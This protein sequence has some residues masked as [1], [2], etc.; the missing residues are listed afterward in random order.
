MRGGGGDG[1]QVTVRKS[2]FDL[3]KNVLRRLQRLVFPMHFGRSDG[4]PPWGGGG[5]QGGGVYRAGGWYESQCGVVV[6]GLIV[7]NAKGNPVPF[8]CCFLLLTYFCLYH[9]AVS[10]T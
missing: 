3:K 4:P 9:A 1:H 5:L 2:Q 7:S 8:L 6:C 10:V